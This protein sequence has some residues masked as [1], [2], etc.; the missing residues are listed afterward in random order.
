[1][2]SY[3]GGGAH[4]S[5]CV[6]WPSDGMSQT[7][8]ATFLLRFPP[9]LGKGPLTPWLPGLRVSVSFASSLFLA[10]T[11][12]K[13]GKWKISDAHPF[14]SMAM[15]TLL[16]QTFIIFMKFL[17]TRR[18]IFLT[19]IHYRQLWITKSEIKSSVPLSSHVSHFAVLSSIL[20][21]CM[22]VFCSQMAEIL[23]HM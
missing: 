3:L 19:I 4:A 9:A 7:T 10:S 1:M 15:A 18:F 8:V 20:F 13:S 5:S 6:P 11:L 23:L 21:L 2:H 14:F 17:C 12:K 22:S 16:T